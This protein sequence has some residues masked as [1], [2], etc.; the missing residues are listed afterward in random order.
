MFHFAMV[1]EFRLM[2]EWRDV[3]FELFHDEIFPRNRPAVL[4]GLVTHWPA[5]EAGMRSPQA[6]FDYVKR[7]DR[8][9][10]VGTLIAPPALR[11]RFFYSD[12]MRGFNFERRIEAFAA[13]MGRLMQ[14]LSEADP[15]A[16]YIES[17]PI[18][19]CLPEFARENVLGLVRPIM[20]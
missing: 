20:T 3:T 4:R 6:F 1:H 14:T 17:A 15:P 9:A 10:Q 13:A 8:G 11:G 18:A 16:V 12:D 2:P 7:F 19:H 5:T